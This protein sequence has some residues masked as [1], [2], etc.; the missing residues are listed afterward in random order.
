MLVPLAVHVVGCLSFSLEDQAFFLLNSKDL[1]ADVLV[2]S[3]Q[4]MMG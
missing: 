4:L 1:P 3:K 2:F